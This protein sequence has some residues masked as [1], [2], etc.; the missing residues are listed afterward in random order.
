MS[1]GVRREGVSAL[2]R[3]GRALG[4]NKAKQTECTRKVGDAIFGMQ[5]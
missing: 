1:E 3:V 2:E 4:R 5:W